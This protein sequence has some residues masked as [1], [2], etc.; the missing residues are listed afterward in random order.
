[1]KDHLYLIAILIN[2]SHVIK[3]EHLENGMV[4]MNML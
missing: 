3:A 4:I 2:G 1:M